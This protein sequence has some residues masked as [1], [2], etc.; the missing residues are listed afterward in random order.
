MNSFFCSTIYQL[1][2]LSI[3]W[4]RSVSE[5]CSNLII[6][7]PLLPSSFFISFTWLPIPLYVPYTCLVL[8]LKLILG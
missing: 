2:S 8:K 4:A 1:N 3:V 5:E 7:K 6:S